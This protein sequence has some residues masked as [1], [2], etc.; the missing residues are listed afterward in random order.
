M[1][2]PP[3]G[4]DDTEIRPSRVQIAFQPIRWRS[5]S[6]LFQCLNIRGF[7]F[8][9]LGALEKNVLEPKEHWAV[10][11]TFFLALRMMLAMHGHPLLRGRARIYP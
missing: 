4:L 11:V 6:V 1:L 2:E 5:A 3:A 7:R 9:I 8:V 10:G